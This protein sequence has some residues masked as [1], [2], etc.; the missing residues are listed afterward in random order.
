MKRII[1]IKCKKELIENLKNKIFQDYDELLK[2]HSKKFEKKTIKKSFLK[3]RL[4]A[5]LLAFRSIQP[6]VIFPIIS[7]LEKKMK[8]KL[9]LAPFFYIRYCYPNQYFLKGHKNSALYTEPHYDKY[10]F[11]NK[12]LSFWIPLHRTTS[13]SGTL[14]YIKKNKEISKEF[15]QKGKNRFNIINYLKEFKSVD[16]K[17]KKNIK[18]VYCDFGEI[19]CFDQNVLHGASR[20][21]KQTRISLNFQISFSKKIYNDKKFYYSNKHLEEKN[22]LNSLNFGDFAFYKKNEKKFND[23]FENKNIPKYLKKNFNKFI[24]NKKKIKKNELLQ[25]VHYSKEDKWLN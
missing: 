12:G 15:P 9:Y 13:Q 6:K 8:K 20:P 10:T 11:E 2:D 1:K 17:I 14:C 22:L 7:Y 19:L 25:D 3:Q 16:K 18:N 23:I 21:M 5:R 4:F 24:K